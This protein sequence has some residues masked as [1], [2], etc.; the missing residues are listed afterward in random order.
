MISARASS[1]TTHL[2]NG[3]LVEANE[4]ALARNLGRRHQSVVRLSC[5]TDRMWTAPRTA[6]RSPTSRRT[7]AASETSG[8]ATPGQLDAIETVLHDADTRV[9]SRPFVTN[10]T[11][12][13][14]R[15]SACIEGQRSAR[16]L[17]GGLGSTDTTGPSR[18]I[19]EGGPTAPEGGRG[20]QPSAARHGR[21]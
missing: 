3:L 1:T 18:Q 16:A 7:A 21:W 2:A 15:W 13:P 9:R 12:E 5:M 20:R 14:E 11:P 17:V 4:D 19:S 10:E 6:P 8:P